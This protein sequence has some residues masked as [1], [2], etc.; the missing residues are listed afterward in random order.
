[1]LHLRWLWLWRFLHGRSTNR[2]PAATP[3][4]AAEVVTQESQFTVAHLGIQDLGVLRIQGTRAEHPV[5][6]VWLDCSSRRASQ[7]RVG[8]RCRVDHS[9]Q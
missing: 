5:T 9:P 3:A 4:T 7:H 1:V 6:P 2:D 8:F